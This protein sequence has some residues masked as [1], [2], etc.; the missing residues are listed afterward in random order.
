MIQNFCTSLQPKEVAPTKVLDPGSFHSSEAVGEEQ[1]YQEAVKISEK[2]SL[3]LI[4]LQL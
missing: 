4:G 2:I 3:I 1:D